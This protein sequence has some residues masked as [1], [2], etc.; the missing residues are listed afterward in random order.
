MQT[1]VM[2][3]NDPRALTLALEIIKRG[4][5]VAFPTDTIYG[6]G[7]AVFNERAVDQIHAVRGRNGGKPIPVLI[8]DPDQLELVAS[9]VNL[10]SEK[11]ARRFWP[12]PLTIILPRQPGIPQAV[13]TLA[14]VGVRIPN[15]APTLELLNQSGPLAVSSASLAGMNGA[16][17]VPGVLAQLD[18]RIPLILDGG[19][20]PGGIPST[21]VDCTLTGP[22]IIREG[23][24]SLEQLQNALV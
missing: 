6:L 10:Q 24:I 19:T 3:I 18:G 14:T 1:L 15:F 12:G 11:L 23:P 9:R 5:L 8:G 4:G 21:V 17:T 7:A 22:L 2:A 16:C 20:T 13:S